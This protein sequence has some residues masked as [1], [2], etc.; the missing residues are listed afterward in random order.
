MCFMTSQIMTYVCF[1]SSQFMIYVCFMSSPNADFSVLS[2]C[3]IG[4]TTPDYQILSAFT[5]EE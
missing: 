2:S 5:S 3:S 4:F 1:M